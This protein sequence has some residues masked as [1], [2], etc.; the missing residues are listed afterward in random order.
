MKQLLVVDGRTVCEFDPA[1]RK[2]YERYL[3]FKGVKIENARGRYRTTS[4]SRRAMTCL[5]ARLEQQEMIQGGLF[6]A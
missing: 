3:A 6:D 5:R 1:E 4:S 2:R